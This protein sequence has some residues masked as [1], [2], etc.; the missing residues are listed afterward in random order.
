MHM[1]HTRKVL[2][3]L[4]SKELF[5]DD[6]GMISI[7]LSYDRWPFPFP[8]HPSSFHLSSYYISIFFPSHLFPS[9]LFTSHPI[10]SHL[11]SLP[12]FFALPLFPI[13]SYSIPFLFPFHPI[14]LCPMSPRE[15]IGRNGLHPS[16]CASIRFLALPLGTFNCRY[17]CFVWVYFVL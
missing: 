3:L 6:I 1:Q 12:S 16:V 10:L 17:T 4:F 8:C 11:L 14:S 13:P 7:R 15:R 9:H 5:E 2:W